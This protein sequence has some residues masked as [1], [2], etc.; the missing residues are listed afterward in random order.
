MFYKDQSEDYSPLFWIAGR[1]IYVNT[2]LLLVEIAAFAI[3]ALCVAFAGPGVL[4][5]LGLGN[6]QVIHEW[7]VWRLFSYVIFPPQIAI[8]F[9]FAMGFLFYFGRQVEQFVGRKSYIQLFA[10]LVLIPSIFFCLLGF[11]GVGGMNY[12]GGYGS[13]FGVFVAFA[14]IYPSAE[15]NFCFVCLCAKHWAYALLGVLTLANVAFHEW[16]SLGFLWGD[17]GIAYLGMRLLGVGRGMEWLT[18]WVEERRARKL[19]AERNFKIVKEREAVESTDAIL[20]KISKH[21]VGSLS[22]SERAVLERARTNL[23]K[24]DQR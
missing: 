3:T 12:M 6:L 1:P 11:T 8:G 13:I 21:G 17:A 18:D 10:A 20:D 9:I 5:L 19:A 24:R 16:T 22:S 15:I 4:S 2:F 23:L 14:T 7:Q